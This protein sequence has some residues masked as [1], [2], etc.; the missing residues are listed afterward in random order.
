L[1]PGAKAIAVLLDPDTP[2]ADAE[3]QDVRA[4]ALAVGQH[5]II[6]DARNDDALAAAFGAIVRPKAGALLV[7]GSA[8]LN[9]HSH[10]IVAFAAEHELPAMYFQRDSVSAGGLMSY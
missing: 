2:T 3:R 4:G 6:L 7:G 8:F 1:A 10:Q 9:S 5:L